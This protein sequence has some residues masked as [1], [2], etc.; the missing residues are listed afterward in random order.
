[1]VTFSISI[2]MTPRRE[3][4]F[5]I[6][7]SEPGA[8]CKAADGKML[9]AAARGPAAGSG[10]KKHRKNAEMDKKTVEIAAGIG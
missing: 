8:L 3:I 5:A 7:L 1:M 9:A 2:K 6:I 10:R 4:Y